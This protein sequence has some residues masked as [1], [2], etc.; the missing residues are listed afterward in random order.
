MTMFDDSFPAFAVDAGSCA[1]FTQEGAWHGHKPLVFAI[2][3]YLRPQVL[4][5]LGTH[6]GNSFFSFCH[7]A[8]L[9][10]DIDPG[11]AD[12]RFHAVDTWQ[13]D[14]HAGG[15]TDTVYTTVKTYAEA[16]F[17]D[18][19]QLWRMAFDEAVDEF[20]DGSVDLLHIDGL[21]TYAAVRHDFESWRPKLSD[22]SVVLF[23]DIAETKADF[24][25]YRL[26]HELQQQ[27]ESVSLMHSHGLGILLV[28]DDIP[29]RFRS[30]V[31]TLQAQPE[32]VGQHLQRR[33][34]TRLLAHRCPSQ[35]GWQ[36]AMTD[37]ES[38]QTVQEEAPAPDQ[39]ITEH[40]TAQLTQE[41]AERTDLQHTIEALQA[42]RSWRLTT[43]FRW[44]GAWARRLRDEG[45]DLSGAMAERGG[46]LATVRLAWPYLQG[47]HF[48]LLAD[49]THANLTDGDDYGRW[50]VLYDAP[51]PKRLRI[52]D[53]T[54][55]GLQARPTF[56]VVMPCY[57]PDLGWLKAAV[58]SVKT[59]VYADWQLCIADD[60]STDP[61]IQSFLREAEAADSRIQCVF[62]S[63][64]G[65]ISAASNSA[66]EVATGDW[67]VLLD[68]DDELHPEAL[69][70]VADAIDRHP[71]ARLVYSDEDKLD[72]N[73]VRH[74]PYFKPDFNY[75]LF[76]TQN[77]VS[78]LGVYHAESVRQ[79]GGFRAGLEGAQDWDL[80]LRF[81]AAFG[82][83]ALVH[84]PRL[85]YHWRVHP[86]STAGGL[87]AKKYALT[88]AT[89][90]VQDY[91]DQVNIPARAEPH[92]TIDHVRVCYPVPDPEP[93][94]SIIIPTRD[95]ADLLAT[96]LD[97][98]MAKTAYTN[99]EILVVDNGSVCEQTLAYLKEIETRW[100]SVQVVRDDRPFNFS[101]LNN[102]AA[103]LAKGKYLCLLNDDIEVITPTWLSEMIAQAVQPG[104][105]CVGAKLYY[106]NDL[107]QHA[108]VI[109]GLAGGVAG[110]AHHMLPRDNAGYF[111]RAQLPQTMSAVT[112]AC[113]VVKKQL[114]E[115]VG[116][117]DEEHFAV[118][119]NDVDLCLR[120]RESGYRNVWTPYAE[121]YHHESVSR[122]SEHAGE[123]KR[124]FERELAAMKA[125]WGNLLLNDPAYNP[126]LSLDTGHFNYAFPPRLSS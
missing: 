95:H 79:V 92:P 68:N 117:L 96:C 118:A 14:P 33:A 27:Y 76:L 36:P 8:R 13:G 47:G 16:H 80:A 30:F 45:R 11:Y 35:D 109:L 2:V 44:A 34:E 75:D 64:N 112:A 53:K 28:G 58:E 18:F 123:N 101:A 83:D 7:A 104:V 84:V 51:D 37:G 21:H 4:A 50:L 120:I 38:I 103:R 42:S 97:S 94:V 125:R 41:R 115:S 86:D 113:L 63:T 23:H 49:K 66:I 100:S 70:W 121:L 116:G 126:N 15:Y 39:R 91:L 56:S 82:A 73:G 61:A 40:L 85:L 60:A 89:R 102:A 3:N 81:L 48:R 55:A 25:V 24:G 77:M 20:A 57:N 88:A 124:R 90:A 43:P 93:L 105:G 107:I 119:F 32:W 74:T 1:F 71:E 26:W 110:H 69:L 9:V 111:G 72:E 122:G 12:Y 5:E 17:A 67:I 98:V 62:R 19:A 46:P 31:Q 65:H 54:L 87:E 29:T 106:P 52:R 22:H 59:Q 99:F 78:H 10:S 6:S 114:F 108:G